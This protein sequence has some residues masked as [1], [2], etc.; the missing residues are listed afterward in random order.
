MAALLYGA[1]Q[2][3]HGI[4]T[5]LKCRNRKISLTM[6]EQGSLTLFNSKLSSPPEDKT[7][8]SLSVFIQ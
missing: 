4:R 1:Y 5:G 8:P 7:S 6:P 3:D 2:N